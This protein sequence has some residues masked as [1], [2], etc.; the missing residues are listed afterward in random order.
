MP[1]GG[2][3]G[4]IA[5]RANPHGV[6]V[7]N[8]STCDGICPAPSVVLCRRRSSTINPLDARGRFLDNAAI[9]QRLFKPPTCPS[10][11]DTG[12][13][14]H[15]LHIMVNLGVI[16]HGSRHKCTRIRAACH[17]YERHGLRRSWPNQ[18]FTGAA[19][20]RR[21]PPFGRACLRCGHGGTI[22]LHVRREA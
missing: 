22:S 6:C 10:V 5:S 13:P 15:F 3:V 1:C 20:R 4:G 7:M 16:G 21:N 17:E 14:R 18:S 2:E 19:R 9:V 11:S 12:E 8:R